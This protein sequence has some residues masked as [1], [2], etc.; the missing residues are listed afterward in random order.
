MNVLGFIGLY[1]LTNVVLTIALA[2]TG[3]DFITA[4]SGAA[5]A[6]A[7]VGPGAGILIG[8]AGNYSPLPSAAKWLLCAGMIVGRLEVFTVLVLF[9]RGFWKH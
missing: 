6:I 8:P 4:L 5:T 9:T 7:N 1:F 2:F 3:L